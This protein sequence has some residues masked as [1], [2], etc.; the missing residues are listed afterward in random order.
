MNTLIAVVLFCTAMDKCAFYSS[1]ELFNT[2][3]EC[4][5]HLITVFEKL[6]ENGVPFFKG[7]CVS[8]GKSI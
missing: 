4:R 2:Q 6:D 8:I 1:K 5:K 7:T 3:E